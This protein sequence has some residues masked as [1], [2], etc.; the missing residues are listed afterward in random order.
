MSRN[1][2]G[3]AKLRSMYACLNGSISHEN[4]WSTA[5]FAPYSRSVATPILSSASNG[6][7]VPEHIVATRR[8]RPSF[9]MKS[10]SSGSF[11]TMS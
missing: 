1:K 6:D 3:G 5:S 11:F 9:L 7:S 4:T 8:G 2:M 10:R